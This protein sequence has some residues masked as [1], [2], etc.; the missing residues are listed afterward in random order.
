MPSCQVKETNIQTSSYGIL[1]ALLIPLIP[2]LVGGAVVGTAAYLIMRK[3]AATR[4]ED[5]LK[6]RI[7]ENLSPERAR[8]ICAPII[9]K[10]PIIPSWVIPIAGVLLVGAIVYKKI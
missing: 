10:R 6:N 3:P 1:P 8:E 4:Y 9:A 2:Y 5:C 7:K